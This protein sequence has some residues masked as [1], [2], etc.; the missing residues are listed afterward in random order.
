MSQEMVDKLKMKAEKHPTSYKLA[1]FKKGN[2]V[3]VD[4]HCLVSF[5]IG[6]SYQDEV[7]CDVVPM[8]ACHLL[9][10]RPWQYDRKALHDGYKNTYMFVK[11]GVKVI[12]GPSRHG[13]VA[14]YNQQEGAN[15][16]TM[17]EF[18]EEIQEETYVYALVVQE[19]NVGSL[20][21]QQLDPLMEEFSD[22]IPE[23]LPRGLPPMRDVQHQIDL[24]PGS[25]LPNKAAY[26]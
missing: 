20:I 17:A 6:K 16:L 26:H 7:W 4:K 3:N 18:M 9:L 25:S 21:P 14:K 15:F 11:D 2:E 24:I 1:W 23:E 8:D 22:V 12:L 19:Q 13:A 10:G 5:S